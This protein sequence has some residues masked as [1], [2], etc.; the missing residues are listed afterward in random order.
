MIKLTDE[1][2]PRDV[3]D[4]ILEKEHSDLDLSALLITKLKQGTDEWLLKKATHMLKSQF[5][6]G[7]PLI[8]NEIAGID[9]D[10]STMTP[11]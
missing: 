6:K 3:L 2:S 11:E 7:T 8:N 1:V 9:H 4:D 5:T 10:F